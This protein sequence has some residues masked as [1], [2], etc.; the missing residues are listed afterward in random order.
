MNTYHIGYKLFRKRKDGSYAPLF[1]NKTQRLYLHEIYHAES[2]PTKGYAYRPYWH[3]CHSPN[4][5]HL[6]NKNRVWCKVE[7]LLEKIINRPESQG[8]KWFL[9]SQIKILEEC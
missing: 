5:P 3:I 6:S 7:F 2:H 4:A 1:I 8:G 9:A